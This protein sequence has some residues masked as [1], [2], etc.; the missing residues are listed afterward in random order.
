MKLKNNLAQIL[1]N[2]IELRSSGTTGLKKK[3]YQSPF[4]L[5][6]ANKVARECQQISSKSK[7]YTVCK[8]EHA[9]GL[10][11]QTLP[12]FEVGAEVNIE[13]FNAYK[14]CKKIKNFTHSHLTP[15]HAKAIR[16]TKSFKNLDLKNIWITCGSEPID[17]D[18]IADFVKKGCTFMVNWGM[19]EVGPCAIN[20]VFKD[21]EKVYEYKKRA[22]KGNLMGDI[23]YCDTKIKNSTLHVKGN[24]SVYDNKWFDTKDLVKINKDNHFYIQGRSE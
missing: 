6:N 3:I 2:G 15:N 5:K 10:L 1:K 11:A 13:S 23:T 14:F 16:L 12:A 19:T 4:K 9:G 22:I 17:W 20:T 21:L 24:I 8:M 18:L 7:V